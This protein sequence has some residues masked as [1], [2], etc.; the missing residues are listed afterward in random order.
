MYNLLP[1]LAPSFE[2]TACAYAGLI[3]RA[4]QELGQMKL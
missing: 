3:G 1:S 2:V 4:D